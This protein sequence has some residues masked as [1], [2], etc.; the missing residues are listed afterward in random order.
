[1]IVLNQKPWPSINSF[2]IA[3]V[4]GHAELMLREEVPRRTGHSHVDAIPKS[5]AGTAAEGPE[6]N[7]LAAA[8]AYAG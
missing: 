4:I 6:A 5:V 1:V 8:P 7:G 3:H 2:T